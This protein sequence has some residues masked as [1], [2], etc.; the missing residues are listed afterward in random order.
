MTQRI[1]E[2]PHRTRQLMHPPSTAR[3]KYTTSQR[4][5]QANATASRCS[6]VAQYRCVASYLQLTQH[7]PAS[8]VQHPLTD[9][10]AHVPPP[11]EV[12]VLPPIPP[13]NDAMPHEPAIRSPFLSR[14]RAAA[15]VTLSWALLLCAPAW[16]TGSRRRRATGYCSFT[17]PPGASSAVHR[18]ISGTSSKP[19]AVRCGWRPASVCS[20]STAN[21]SPGRQHRRAKPTHRTT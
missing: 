19:M 20:S 16:A 4:G 2:H 15:V 17:T 9:F 14:L 5:H 13:D 10:A 6:R 21:T 11:K 3:S 1:A 8:Q 12:V 7:A 18:P